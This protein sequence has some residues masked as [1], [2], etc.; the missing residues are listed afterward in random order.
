MASNV[1]WRQ[2]VPHMATIAGIYGLTQVKDDIFETQ[3][4]QESVDQN[5]VYAAAAVNMALGYVSAYALLS[6]FNAALKP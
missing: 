5:I 1:A 2:K 4:P 6:L 3:K